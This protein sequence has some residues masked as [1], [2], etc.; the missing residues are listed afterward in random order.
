MS[1]S[2]EFWSKNK[3]LARV[4]AHPRAF[5]SSP[6]AP[7]CIW[8]E[9]FRKS[10]PWAAS[11]GVD[12]GTDLRLSRFLVSPELLHPG[13]P[14]I[15]GIQNSAR[16]PEPGILGSLLWVGRWLLGG[17]GSPWQ[18]F[19]GWD[20]GSWEAVGVHGKPFLGVV[21]GP[22]DGGSPWQAFSGWDG[23]SWEAVGVHGMPFLGGDR[24]GGRRESMA[25][26]CGW[27]GGCRESVA[28][29]FWVGRRFLGGGGSPRQAFSGW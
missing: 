8:F 14:G 13:I 1:V 29:L 23:G 20:G 16:N 12:Q 22:G 2:L 28:G 18:A 7:T 4:L 6:G 15:S 27:D 19:P 9:A 11:P 24:S 26:L 17:G 21:T 5:G 3:R 10:A 25:G